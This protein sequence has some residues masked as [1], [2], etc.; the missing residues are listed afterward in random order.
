MQ[1]HFLRG[2]CRNKFKV[3]RGIRF[4]LLVY[5]LTWVLLMWQKVQKY[6]GGGW[7]VRIRAG[8]FGEVK[9]GLY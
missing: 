8:R 1:R 5:P 2:L 4:L 3:T 7:L 9:W 6:W